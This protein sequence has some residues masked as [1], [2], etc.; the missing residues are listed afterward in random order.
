M[1]DDADVESARKRG[2]IFSGGIGAGIAGGAA[3]LGV[4]SVMPSLEHAAKGSG[5]MAKHLAKAAPHARLAV[6]P[7]AVAGGVMGLREKRL[8]MALA[9][10]PRKQ[11]EYMRSTG[12]APSPLAVKTGGMSTPYDTD[13]VLRG[14][15]SE[16]H[17]SEGVELANVENIQGFLEAAFANK[18]RMHKQVEAQLRAA[19]PQAAAKGYG[20]ARAVGVPAKDASDMVLRALSAAPKEPINR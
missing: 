6:L 4:E 10:D 2:L 3:R 12:A 15:S 18:D 14:R 5:R 11:R 16:G 17:S 1:S 20:R 7:A 9:S 13:K 8:Q 19:Y